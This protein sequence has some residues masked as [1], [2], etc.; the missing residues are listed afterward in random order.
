MAEIVRRLRRQSVGSFSG[1]TIQVCLS[2]DTLQL[3]E[4]LQ[5]RHNVSRSAAAH[6]LIRLGLGL[7]PTPPFTNG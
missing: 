3:I 1:A 5:R 2:S 6:H 7:S 4:K